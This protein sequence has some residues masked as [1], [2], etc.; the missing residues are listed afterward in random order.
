MKRTI[1]HISQ[2]H[3]RSTL[4]ALLLLLTC[5]SAS[6][7]AKEQISARNVDF[8]I[9]DQYLVVTADFILDSLKLGSN[10]QVLI[11]PI[12]ETGSTESDDAQRATDNSERKILPSVLVNGRNMH[13]SYQRGVL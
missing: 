9:T 5:A 12:L 10:K 7:G 4:L 8:Y 2:S 11:T 3:V 6:A 13:I 1:T